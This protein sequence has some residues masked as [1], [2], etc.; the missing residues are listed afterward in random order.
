MRVIHTPPD[1][2]KPVINVKIKVPNNQKDQ[3]ESNEDWQMQ[4]RNAR[5]AFDDRFSLYTAMSMN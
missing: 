2:E 5:H 3:G 1:D 4:A